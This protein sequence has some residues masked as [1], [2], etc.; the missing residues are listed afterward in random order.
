[1]NR[2]FTLVSL[3][4]LS[5][6]T[7]MAQNECDGVR[8]RTQNLFPDVTVTSAVTYGSNAALGG[9]NATLRLDV[10]E[11]TGDTE[12]TRPVVVVAF[13]GSFI[14]G[15]RGD[16]ASI[17]RI[18]A[19]LG[20]VAIAPDYRVGFF[21]PNQITTTLA[22]FRGAHDM[23]AVVRFLRK[24]VAESGNPY[25]IDPD[26]IIVGGVSAGAIAAIHAAYLDKL[27]EMPAYMVNDTAGLGGVEGNSGSLGYSSRPLAVM[28]FSG[29]IGDTS[30]IEQSDLPIVSIHEDGDETV[31]YGTQ[32]INAIGIAT[33]LIASGSRDI[34]VRADNLGIDNCLLTYPNVVN[35][36]GYLASGF[37]PVALEFVTRFCADMVCGGESICA[38]NFVGVEEV[39]AQRDPL[40]LYP[41]PTTGNLQFTA[42][43][44]GTVEVIDMT[45]RMLISRQVTAG[46][47]Q[48]D[49]QGLPCGAYVL[50]LIGQDV[51]TVR[52]VKE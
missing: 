9:G 42:S 11:P 34:H 7:L 18:F 41:N 24:S 44:Q 2:I 29:T 16:V 31:P 15:S 36:V 3:A 6:A 39:A 28:S 5:A 12:T 43:A 33:G 46:R 27:E 14:S 19:K 10:Y 17:C 20:Y 13:G 51:T 35:H 23:K 45:G 26:R 52:F 25:G 47:Q 32:E 38:S 40:N 30:W 37:D 1:M 48:L 21:L 22:V 49:V 4:V 50:R 8:Y